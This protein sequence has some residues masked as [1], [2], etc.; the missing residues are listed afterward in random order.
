MANKKKKIAVKRKP[1]TKKPTKPKKRVRKK[2]QTKGAGIFGNHFPTNRT[3]DSNQYWQ[4][5]AE[6]AGA[7]GWCWPIL[8]TDRS[9]TIARRRICL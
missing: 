6:I 5:R 2:K 9:T 1:K 4:L 3:V 8:K 7:E